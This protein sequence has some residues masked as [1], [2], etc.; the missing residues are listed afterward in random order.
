M[1]YIKEELSKKDKDKILDNLS[2]NLPVLR[3]KL[4]VSQEDLAKK[5]GVS[6]QTIASIEAKKGKTAWPTVIAILLLFLVNPL[7][8]GLVFGLGIVN[9]S[10]ISYLG[11]SSI[12][13]FLSNK[14]EKG[15]E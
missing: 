2:E 7:T 12:L 9:K 13:N 15:G 3:A 11:L 5:L 14:N 6:R 4:G 1:I 8:S 10:I